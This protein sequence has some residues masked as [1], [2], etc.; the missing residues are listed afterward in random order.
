MK[1]WAHRGA[2]EQAPENTMAAFIKAVELN[3][4]GIELDVQ[5]SKDGRVVVIHDER[6]DRTS[7]GTGFVKDLFYEELV[8]FNY[9]N[10]FEIDDHI[11]LPLLED[12]IQFLKP[13][14]LDLNIELKTD[15]IR[16]EGIEDKVNGILIQH[17]FVER[18]IISSFNHMS[19]L[20]MKEINKN[21]SI[22]A[23]LRDTIIDPIKY[24]EKYGLDAIH[25][26]ISVFKNYINGND[27]SVDDEVLI[28]VWGG[29]SKDIPRCSSS[30]VNAFIFDC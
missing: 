27:Y 3:V 15:K 9:N 4:D 18:T 10:K 19:L 1:I 23:L 7:N 17:N 8:A 14:E 2:A 16:Y 28:N 29:V 24:A 21:V 11:K 12:V 22:G 30:G 20:K 26:H 13:Y 5:L 25:P 6:V